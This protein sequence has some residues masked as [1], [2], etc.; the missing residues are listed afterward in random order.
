[1]TTNTAS[2][3]LNVIDVISASHG[4]DISE[5]RE[6]ASKFSPVKEQDMDETSYSP[7]TRYHYKDGSVLEI[8]ISW[9]DVV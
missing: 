8:S 7:T 2:K 9:A 5:A 6:I 3:V 1:M 4:Y